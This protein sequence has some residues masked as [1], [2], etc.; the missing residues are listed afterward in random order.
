MEAFYSR[1]ADNFIGIILQACFIKCLNGGAPVL[2]NSV[3]SAIKQYKGNVCRILS[4]KSLNV[5]PDV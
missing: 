3:L 5:E 4:F 1:K 2:I